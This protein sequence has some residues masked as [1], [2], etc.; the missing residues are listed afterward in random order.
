MTEEQRKAIELL[1]S[2]KNEQKLDGEQIISE[3][4]YYFLLDFIIDGPK[5]VTPPVIQPMLPQPLT[6]YYSQ[7]WNTTC[8][9]DK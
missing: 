4:E 3:D 2:I 6:P 7:Q 9:N 8:V 1:N 5:I